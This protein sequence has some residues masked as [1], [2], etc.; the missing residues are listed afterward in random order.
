MTALAWLLLGLLAALPLLAWLIPA[1]S[2]PS[3]SCAVCGQFKLPRAVLCFD[4]TTR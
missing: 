2:K 4:C 1:A 3:T